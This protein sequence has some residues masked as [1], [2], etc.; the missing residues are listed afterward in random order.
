MS[1][2]HNVG[3]LDSRIRIVL[4]VVC[5]GLLGYHV[6]VSRFM[7]IYVL[8]AVIVLIAYFLKTGITRSCP[9]MKAMDVSTAGKE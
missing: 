6:I 7:G 8:V 4:G 5:V 9:I 2:D 1:A 3:L